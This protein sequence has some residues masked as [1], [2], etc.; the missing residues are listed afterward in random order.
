MELK[1][2][3]YKGIT[4]R[5]TR[6]KPDEDGGVHYKYTHSLMSGWT[7]IPYGNNKSYVVD[8]AKASIDEVLRNQP[9]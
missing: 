6:N 2:E 4:I 7:S 9:Q 5:V 3:T 1:P 8:Y